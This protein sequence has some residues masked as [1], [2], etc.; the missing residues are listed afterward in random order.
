MR[1]H[2]LKI[3]KRTAMPHTMRV[4]AT[5][6]I[7]MFCTSAAL[8][9]SASY[10]TKGA[11][12]WLSDCNGLPVECI[13]VSVTRGSVNGQASTSLGYSI[14]SGDL[15]CGVYSEIIGFGEI[16]DATFQ[17]HGSTYSVDVDLRTVPGF[18]SEVCTYDP[19]TQERTC[20]PTPPGIVIGT[21]SALTTLT[22]QGRATFIESDPNAQFISSQNDLG[23][24]AI[25][26]VNLLGRNIETLGGIFRDR[27]TQ[28]VVA[29]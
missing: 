14:L 25:A 21:W 6:I 23:F 20:N 26:N 28:I 12:A 7:L 17:V 13:F 24:R 11:T 29:H 10:R 1:T 15:C 8:S 4:F 27:L 3:G 19:Y 9:Q 16:P 2:R 22:S 18:F 5:L